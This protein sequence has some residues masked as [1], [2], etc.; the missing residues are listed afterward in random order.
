MIGAP[1][2]VERPSMNINR[3]FVCGELNPDGGQRVGHPADG[4]RK[5]RMIR[6]KLQQQIIEAAGGRL[7]F[8]R[9]QPLL[10]SSL[11]LQIIGKLLESRQRIG[12]DALSLR[13]FRTKRV[14]C[15]QKPLLIHTA[16]VAEGAARSKSMRTH[17]LAGA[18]LSA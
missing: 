13:K 14:E 17:A 5:L 10:A 8:A 4:N 9:R 2:E 18:M 16:S 11:A 1:F 15:F 6:F 12:V 7:H 3:P